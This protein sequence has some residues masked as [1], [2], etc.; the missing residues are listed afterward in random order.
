MK[1][2]VTIIFLFP[3]SLVFSQKSELP[4]TYWADS[5]HYVDVA[6]NDTVEFFS[7]YGC[8][9]I[10]E[11]YGIG[12]YEIRD[13]L[14]IIN[15]DTPKNAMNSSH[16]TIRELDQMNNIHLQVMN[17]GQPVP[18]CNF[19]IKDK[20][21]QKILMG[22]STNDTG[23]VEFTVSDSKLNER[24][25]IEITYLG[26][27]S[28]TIQLIDVLGKSITENLKPFRVIQDKMVHFKIREVTDSIQLLG[29]IYSNTKDAKMNLRDKFRMM[30]TNWPWH[31]NF[32][33]SHAAIP[34]EFERK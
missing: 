13:S 24:L 29:P 4:G 33:Y 30:F 11:V 25:F 5:T 3:L 26:M 27:D 1:H 18:S 16:K 21:T 9:L 28:Y 10:T 8:C 23:F 20:Q 14:L 19:V 2:L 15:T 34:R 17:S 22:G 32:S 6:S 12:A 7:E 31:W